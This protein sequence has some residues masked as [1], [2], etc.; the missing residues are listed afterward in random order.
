[1]TYLSTNTNDQRPTTN[2]RI[3][4]TNDQR[5]TTNGFTI[6]ELVMVILILGVIAAFAM[7]TIGSFGSNKLDAAANKMLF[8]LRYAQQLGIDRH[9]PCGVSFDTSGNS[10][11]VY[12]GDISTLAI[13]PYRKK[14]LSVD[15]DTDDELK[16]VGLASASFGTIIYFDYM[17]TPYVSGG[18]LLS[19]EG[20]IALQYGTASKTIRIQPNTGETKIQ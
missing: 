13:D 16:G 17:G 5:L 14:D 4:T 8:D 19:S 1:M 3:P 20:V 6:I 10:Y 2:D 12:I 11:F 7:A 15:Y 9:V 18:S